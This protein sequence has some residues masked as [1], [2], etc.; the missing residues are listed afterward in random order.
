MVYLALYRGSQDEP[1]EVV[2]NNSR[3]PY[4]AA[5]GFAPMV[6]AYE[7]PYWMLERDVGH[8]FAQ[9]AVEAWY[10]HAHLSINITLLQPLLQDDD[11]ILY[12]S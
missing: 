1:Y 3:H 6:K 2:D 10:K 4:D 8:E 9:E 12:D 7:A 5:Y 11:G